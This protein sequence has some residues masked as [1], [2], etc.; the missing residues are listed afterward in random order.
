MCAGRKAIGN[1]PSPKLLAPLSNPS[2]LVAAATT[3][4]IRAAF[5]PRLLKMLPSPWL[6]L[7]L[8]WKRIGLPTEALKMRKF[9]L[10]IVD[11]DPSI[12]RLVEKHLERASLERVAIHSMTNPS[13]ACAW[14]DNNR[15][16]ILLSD[17]EMPGIGGLEM[18]KFAKQ[19]NSWTQVIFMTANSTWD[20]I[21]ESIENGATDYLLKPIQREEL[22]TLIE[23]AYARIERWEKAIW[24]TLQ[25][26]RTRPCTV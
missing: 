6:N 8:A 11:D 3:G 10:V 18:L 22:V 14:I 9:N 23:Q 24:G 1:G 25:A 2:P 21:A 20:H 5:C 15:C 4:T 13:V 17:V 16:D 26:G 19:R 12:V 7:D